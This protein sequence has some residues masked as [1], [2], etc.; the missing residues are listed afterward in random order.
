MPLDSL[1][2]FIVLPFFLW[3][4]QLVSWWCQIFST[5]FS[6]VLGIIELR[7]RDVTWSICRMSAISNFLRD[8]VAVSS[9]V[10]CKSTSAISHDLQLP[11]KPAWLWAIKH[12]NGWLNLL[13]P[14]CACET[15]RFGT[16]SENWTWNSKSCA[17]PI[18]KRGGCAGV[19]NSLH[20]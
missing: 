2:H 7:H 19:A 18:S 6:L 4:L 12:D 15:K 17:E 1:D 11:N 13:T 3:L 20:Q 14:S 16:G 10:T 5:Y 9:W 8:C